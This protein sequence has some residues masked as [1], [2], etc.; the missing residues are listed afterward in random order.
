MGY[1]IQHE[2]WA[3][4]GTLSSIAL[5]AWIQPYQS[6]QLLTNYF[7]QYLDE[8]VSIVKTIFESVF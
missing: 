3:T 4:K 7:L 6:D 2:F 1:P 5:T 8:T